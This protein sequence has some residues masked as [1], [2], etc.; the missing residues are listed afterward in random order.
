[1][2][3]W[4]S[5]AGAEAAL[6]LI[7]AWALW[8]A[9][10]IIAALRRQLADLAVTVRLY[11]ETRTDSDRQVRELLG[12]NERLARHLIDRAADIQVRP[13]IAVA[14]ACFQAMRES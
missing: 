8:R 5:I 7:L 2:T 4:R 12:Q 3:F 9:C 13:E 10:D 14:R 1:M 11:R 6:L